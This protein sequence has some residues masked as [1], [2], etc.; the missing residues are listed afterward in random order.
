MDTDNNQYINICNE[1]LAE[2]NP[3]QLALYCN[4]LQS[5]HPCIE[6]ISKTN[7]VIAQETQMSVR[8]VQSTRK[9]LESLG[10]IVVTT[11]PDENGIIRAAPHVC[12]NRVCV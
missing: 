1:A 3:Y 5:F 10:Y 7:K 8:K 9:E 11:Q 4:Y 2:L 6:G 12:L